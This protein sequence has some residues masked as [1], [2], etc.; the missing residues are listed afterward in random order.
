MIAYPPV[1]SEKGVALLSQNR[2]FQWFNTPCYIYPMIPAYAAT[3]LKEKGLEV[4]W[5]DGIAEKISQDD[6]LALLKKEKPDL[7]AIEAKSPII[8]RYWKFIDYLKSK[9]EFKGIKTVLMGDHV[10]ALPEESLENSQVDYVITGGNFDFSLVNLAEHLASGKKLNPGFYFKDKRGKIKNTGRFRGIHY[11]LTELPVIDREL[12]KWWL[13]AY[14][15]GNFKYFP[16]T[17]TMIGRDCWWRRPNKDAVS[18]GVGCTFCSW[19]SIFPYFAVAT[20]EQMIKEVENCL[21]LGIKEI[22]DDT[23]T[24]PVG[25][26]L[27]KFCNLMIEKG[28]NEKIRISCNMRANALSKKEY[29]LMGKA[30]F[31]FILYGLESASQKTLDRLNKGTKWDDIVQATKWAKQAGL[32]PHVTCMVGYPW[33]SKEEAASTIKLTR[34]LFDKGY[35]ETLQGTIVIPYPGTQLWQQCLKNEW[36]KI[37]S[38]D[39]EKLDMREP[40]MISPIPEEEIHRLVQGLYKSFLTPRFILRKITSIRSLNDVKFLLKA[41]W[42]VLGHLKDFLSPEAKPAPKVET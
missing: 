32:D 33:E 42:R 4:V 10:T 29:E 5:A 41:G 11:K 27:E 34:A 14:E 21:R 19:T 22:F 1:P 12:S 13:Y 39:Y 18:E 9:K 2:Q 25:V 23:G 24:F 28:Y 3:M 20:P 31:R 6:F 38:T 40:V 37:G 17:Y 30:G 35:I 8:R 26:W 7:I 36:L 15:N 16:G